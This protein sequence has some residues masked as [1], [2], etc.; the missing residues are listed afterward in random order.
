MNGFAARSLGARG[1]DDPEIRPRVHVDG[2]RGA[3][4][5]AWPGGFAQGGH[6]AALAQR[7]KPLHPVAVHQAHRP[8][9]EFTG[10]FRQKQPH[11]RA[12]RQA[13]LGEKDVRPACAAAHREVA[14]ADLPR[15]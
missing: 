3:P 9:D 4:A 2:L 1:V 12:A 13:L 11:L 14:G 10:L 5:L 15:G 8:L 6:L 7:V